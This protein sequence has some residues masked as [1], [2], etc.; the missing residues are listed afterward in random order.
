MTDS[1]LECK[2][3]VGLFACLVALLQQSIHILR[4]KFWRFGSSVSSSFVS[5]DE[6]SAGLIMPC[7][8]ALGRQRQKLTLSNDAPKETSPLNAFCTI[9]AFFV[10]TSSNAST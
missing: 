1:V 2:L 3:E 9:S 10:W 4:Y 8:V 5:I 6:F 7:Q